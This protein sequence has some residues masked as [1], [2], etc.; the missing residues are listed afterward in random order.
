MRLRPEPPASPGC[1][2]RPGRACAGDEPRPWRALIPRSDRHGGNQ[3]RNSIPPTTARRQTASQSAEGLF[4]VPEAR[5]AALATSAARS[6]VR[7]TRA[8]QFPTPPMAM[9]NPGI[10]Q[11]EQRRL[12]DQIARTCAVVSHQPRPGRP[13][14][15]A[16]TSRNTGPATGSRE[17]GL[18][19]QPSTPSAQDR[20]LAFLSQTPDK[21][22]V[23][24]DRVA[25]A[26]FRQRAPG[27]PSFP[28]RSS[29]GIRSG[30]SPADHRASHREHLR[31]P[32]RSHPSRAARH[33]RRQPI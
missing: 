30:P 6:S 23:S 5:P 15:P 3:G 25:C 7:R 33:T 29:L 22:T 24:P 16:A 32:H 13:D 17:P 14:P 9:P 8:S 1:R 20:Q 27:E 18:A 28:A 31:Q 26:G 11:E 19:P 21:R 12:Q 4:C 2:A 10:S